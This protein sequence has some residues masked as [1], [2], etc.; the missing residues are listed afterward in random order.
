[1]TARRLGRG[2]VLFLRYFVGLFFALAA[3]NKWVE[4]Y[5][6]SD[7]LYR[8]LSDRLQEI[9]PESFGAWFIEN[10]GLPYYLPM[11]WMVCIGETLIALGLLF[12]FMTRWAALGAVLFNVM[13]T[14]GGYYDASLVI[15]TLMYLPMVFLPTGQWVGLDRIMLRRHT[16]SI[17]FR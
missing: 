11:G 16:G 1:M 15:L 10:L 4:N 7:K 8:V 5:M 2:F 13:L 14:I 17:W 6:F 9:D 12:G 3:V